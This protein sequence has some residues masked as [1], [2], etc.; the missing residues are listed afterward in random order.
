MPFTRSLIRSFIALLIVHIVCY[1]HVSAQNIYTKDTWKQRD[2]WQRATEIMKVMGLRP[3]DVI[4]DIGCHQGYMTL[5][6]SKRTGAT[7]KVYAVDVNSSHLRVLNNLIQEAG[8]D[9][10][11]TI[12]GEYDNPR[13]PENSL[14]FA[15]I[16]DAYHEMDDHD[17]ILEHV[18]RALKPDGRLVILEPIGKARRGWDRKRLESKH[19]IAMKY[20]IEDLKQAGYRILHRQDPF[21]DRG[22]KKKD[23][24][25]LLMATPLP[26]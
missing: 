25:W 20:V 22:Q 9:N 12:R 21:I 13:L 23:E 7:G 1:A 17:R 4:A 3:G 6:F 14:D 16:M 26:L 8:I 5:K 18:K 19:E 15:F 24:L 10:I 2:S 11:Q